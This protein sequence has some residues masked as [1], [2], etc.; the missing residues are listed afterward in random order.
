MLL[1]HRPLFTAAVILGSAIA[2]LPRAAQAQAIAPALDGTGTQVTID[3]NTLYIDGGTQAGANLFHSFQQFGLDTGQIAQFLANPDLA[4]ILARVTG[5]NPSQIDGLLQVV[6][7]APNL[8]LMNPAG[9]VFGSNASLNVSGDF[10]ATTADR[11]GFETGGWFNAN[12]SND[13][14]SLVGTPSQ[15]AFLSEQPGAIANAGD[16]TVAPGRNLGLIAGTV[17]NNGTITAPGGNLILAAVPGEQFVRISQPGMLLSIEVPAAALEAGIRPQDLP[18]LLTG[19]DWPAAN[20]GDVAIAGRVWGQ[21]VHLAAAGQVQ[22]SDPNLVRTGNGSWSAPTVTRFASDADAAMTL[23]FLDISIP[24]Y[25]TLLYGG[26]VGTTTI[27]I[28]PEESGIAVISRQLADIAANGREVEEVHIVSEGNAGNFWLGRDFV[29]TAT[30]GQYRDQ[31]QSWRSALSQNAD[32]LLYSCFT[33]LGT[34]G[35]ALINALATETGA[36]VAASTDLTGSSA[37]GGNWQFEL[38]TGDIAADLAFETPIIATYDHTLDIF[39]VNT[40]DA[41]ADHA[42]TLGSLRWAIAQANLDFGND[43]IRFAPDISLINLQNGTLGINTSS[44][45][46]KITGQGRNITIQGDNTFR[47]FETVTT[48][49]N[50]IIFDSLTITRGNTTTNGGAIAG[51]SNNSII[52]V[53]NS[54]IIGNRANQNGGGIFSTGVL[55]LFNTTVSNNQANLGGGIFNDGVANINASSVSKN[56]ANNGGGFY[57][58][59]SATANLSNSTLSGNQASLSGGGAFSSNGSIL[60]LRNTTVASNVAI[61]GDGG[62]LYA[63]NA[64]DVTLASSIVASNVD[65]GGQ[66][67]DVSGGNFVG[68]ANN[69]IG[70]L[71]GQ[72]GGSLGTGSDLVIADPGLAP[73][74]NYGGTTLT[75]ALLPDSP[76]LNA[77]FNASGAALDQR[78]VARQAEGTV[79]IGAYESAGFNVERLIGDAQL[80]SPTIPFNNCCRCA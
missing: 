3:G 19:Y 13:Y 23:T 46:L 61:A 32:L 53:Q 5:G 59:D 27:A 49:A 12:G 44:G 11:I 50:D 54:Q 21:T 8:Y 35:E 66:A 75:H 30:V 62:G 34:M 79:D 29:S 20:P 80:R 74:G 67:P 38:V 68:N 57:N 47:L 40:G 31:L 78:G 70:S 58:V 7:G 14:A 9:I 45:D 24:N 72:T 52:T 63:T 77:G 15:F 1:G 28:T 42:L 10:F 39:T 60:N 73:L 22:P 48:G 17:L 4:N 69:L 16:L 33:A 56:Q 6:G 64:N 65:L 76:A 41:D 2:S 26:R 43:E 25:Q 37:L 51:E 55:N 18:T 36:D 71:A